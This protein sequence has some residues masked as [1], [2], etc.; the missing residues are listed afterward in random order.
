MVNI[1]KTMQ[2]CV[3]K[4]TE[5]AD[6]ERKP[7]GWDLND[8]KEHAWERGGRRAEETRNAEDP[9]QN[10]YWCIYQKNR[11]RARWAKAAE[12]GCGQI[13]YIWI[14]SAIVSHRKVLNRN[15]MLL[16]YYVKM[17][18]NW[19]REDVGRSFRILH[20]SREDVVV[21]WIR[22]GVMEG[23]RSSL[24]QNATPHIKYCT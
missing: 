16:W 24:F 17:N 12:G 18:S 21:A 1:T 2:R 11:K 6:L 23:E 5:K 8:G 9:R 4:V 22:A 7:L 3:E 10:L 20:K 13:M 14:L 15:V 19:A